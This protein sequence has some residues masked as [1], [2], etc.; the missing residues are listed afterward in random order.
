[1]TS[2]AAVPAVSFPALGTTAAVVV[3]DAGALDVAHRMLRAEVD[4]IDAA[5]SRFRADSEISRLQENAGE[6]VTVSPLLAEAIG[7]AWRAAA[8]T[9][10]LVDPTVGTAL[11]RLGYDA[12]FASIDHDDPAPATPPTPAPGWQRIRFDAATRRVLMPPAVGLDLGATAKA[13]AA[14]RAARRIASAAGGGVLVSLGGDIAT[15]GPPPGGGWRVG[16]GD[17]HR[18]A[19]EAP[20]AT[21]TITAGALATSSTTC[22]AWRRAGRDVHHIV[23][24]RTGDVAATV[25]RTVSVAAASC[26][27]ANTASTAAIVLGE[28]APGWLIGVG[29]PARLAGVDGSVLTVAGWPAEVTG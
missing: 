17:D 28:A 4:A 27:D 2:V 1:M 25:W 20:D 12:D 11:T 24:P 10:G 16:I 15:A 3:T 5:C 14:D 7:V 22:R 19:A 8:L 6:E 29:L 21:V 18:A 26:V 23:D 9:D 13:L